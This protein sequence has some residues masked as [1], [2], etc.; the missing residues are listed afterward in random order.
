MKIHY[1]L[2]LLLAAGCH[3]TKRAMNTYGPGLFQH[4]T[5]SYEDDKDQTKVFRPSTYTFPPSR[6]REGFE[7]KEDGTFIR[8]AIG[9]A[10]GTDKMNGT[11]KMKGKDRLIITFGQ[12]KV[13]PFEMKIISLEKAMLTIQ[14]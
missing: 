7:I 5:H 8:Y 2:L 13:P 4:W 6:G 9:P 11:W 12:N 1:V 10:D 14:K 3:P